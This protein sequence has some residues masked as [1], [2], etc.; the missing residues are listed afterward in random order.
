ML[1][2]VLIPTVGMRCVA[3]Q[4]LLLSHHISQ[5]T[6]K[7]MLCVSEPMNASRKYGR[8]LNGPAYQEPQ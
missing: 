5:P 4:H 8:I 6:L 2:L 1:C 3:E 7:E